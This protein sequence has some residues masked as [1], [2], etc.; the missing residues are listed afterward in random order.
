VLR[1][2]RI[3]GELPRAQATQAGLMRLMAGAAA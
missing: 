1:D 2:G 3:A